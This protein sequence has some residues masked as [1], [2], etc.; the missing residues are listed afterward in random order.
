MNTEQQVQS[1]QPIDVGAKLKVIGVGGGGCNAVRRM[2]QQNVRGVEL[3]VA[4]TDIKALMMVDMPN[5]LQ[6]GSKLTRGLGAGAEPNVGRQA[7]E[8]SAEELREALRGADMIFIAAGMGGGTGTGAAPV[9]AEIAKETGALVVAICTLPFAFEGGK[10]MAQANEGLSRM[11]DNVDTL[12]VINNDRLLA[13]TPK[14]TSVDA[15][16]QM[17]D[18]ILVHAVRSISDLITMPGEINV[19]FADVRTIMRGG[20]PAI[21]AIGQGSGESR[22]IEAARAA[23]NNPLLDLSIEGAKG[24]LLS[25]T[26]GN[27]LT[28]N[29]V[30]LVADTV[31]KAVDPDAHI[32]FGVVKDSK[33]D[34]MVQVTVIATGVSEVA[35]SVQHIRSRQIEQAAAS[36]LSIGKEPE[37]A[38]DY[39]TPAYLRSGKTHFR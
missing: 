16:F 37:V 33:S 14:K 15:G 18:D 2:Y 34:K 27:D 5:R 36:A 21:M 22:A 38:I 20:G 32:I 30:N 13:S 6:L 29:E 1:P 25:I 23:I 8:E 26:G 4:N 24:V 19:D 7:A 3:Y 31:A 28:L 39:D 17:A 35:Q 9:V 10:R 12:I 11:R